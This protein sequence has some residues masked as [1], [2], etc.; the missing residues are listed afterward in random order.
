MMSLCTESGVML[1]AYDLDTSYEPRVVL[2]LTTCG[3]G[4]ASRVTLAASEARAT[5]ALLIAA[6]GA[7][8]PMRAVVAGGWVAA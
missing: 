8:E 3:M 4:F 1:D 7:A 5:A 6:T 2:H